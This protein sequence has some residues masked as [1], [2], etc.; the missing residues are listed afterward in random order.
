MINSWYLVGHDVSLKDIEQQTSD[1]LEEFMAVTRGH[2]PV[3]APLEDAQKLIDTINLPAYEAKFVTS[4]NQLLRALEALLISQ[5][6]VLTHYKNDNC[7]LVQAAFALNPL[8]EELNLGIGQEDFAFPPENIACGCMS[9]RTSMNSF[10]DFLGISAPKPLPKNLEFKQ[11]GNTAWG[12]QERPGFLQDY[13]FNEVA[14]EFLT[15]PVPDHYSVSY[16]GHGINSYGLT[17]RFARGN[18]ALIAQ[19][20]FGGFFQDN[21]ESTQRWNEII[22]HVDRAFGATDIR[23]DHPR[24][25]G[26]SLQPIQRTHLFRYSS[27]RGVLESLV[28]VDGEWVIHKAEKELHSHANS[29]QA[30]MDLF[31]K[32]L[33]DICIEA[34]STRQS[35]DLAPYIRRTDLQN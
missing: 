17:V 27:F 11:I 29:W 20:H 32:I 5:Q 10:F 34:F 18:L 8:T 1:L 31:E 35:L 30:E 33:S 3:F 22:S 26:D 6:A 28:L 9:G 21:N 2:S 12:T 7:Q 13:L 24:E 15:G 25:N 4:S 14:E 23:E 19:S 16:G